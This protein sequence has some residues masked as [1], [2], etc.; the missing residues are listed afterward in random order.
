MK[1]IAGKSIL[2]NNTT[3]CTF[4][5]GRADEET[6]LKHDSHSHIEWMGDLTIDVESP[7]KLINK[8]YT[9]IKHGDIEHQKWLKEKIEL[10]IDLNCSY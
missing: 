1:I 5:A 9:E 7:T 6:Q 4:I 3:N 2:H 8:L 10:F